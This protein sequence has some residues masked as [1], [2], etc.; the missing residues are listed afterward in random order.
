VTDPFSYDRD[1]L[2]PYLM[3]D[4]E[5]HEL[6]GRALGPLDV[7]PS[8]KCP[9]CGRRSY[10]PDDLVNHYCAHCHHFCDDVSET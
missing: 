5:M 6:L 10:H 2:A 1:D 8:W 3:S 7:P 4:A 9:H